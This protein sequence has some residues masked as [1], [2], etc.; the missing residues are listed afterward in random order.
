MTS[1]TPTGR[2][3]FV[4]S[5]VFFILVTAMLVVQ[6]FKPRARIA[7]SAEERLE[8]VGSLADLPEQSRRAYLPGDD[9]APLAKP[10]A[11]EW[12]A[13]FPEPGQTVDEYLRSGPNPF[14]PPRN[15]IYLLPL[16]TFP[17]GDSPSIELLREYTSL[18]F[19]AETMVLPAVDIKALGV[20]HRTNQHTKK[21]QYRTGDLLGVLKKQLPADAYCILG[22]TMADLYPD[23]AW[24][25]V[26]GEALL[27][28][29]AGV[30]SFARFDPAFFGEPRT[31][32][33]SSL[34]LRR[35]C[36]VLTHEAAHMF[37]MY[38][39][40]FYSCLVNG[41]NS[42][43]EADFRPMHECPV[44]LRKLQ[45]S[46]G[47]DP[48]ERYEKLAGFCEKV[49]FNDETGWLRSRLKTLRGR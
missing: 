23:D 24:N 16:G 29:R 2:L 26:F 12:L 22:I 47:F 33:A 7:I 32:D 14:A 45:R 8:A 3:W 44:C 18:Y 27:T 48:I 40:V 39:C 28:E 11:G 20:G 42:M 4:V 6:L 35:S 19:M 46:I 41:S 13:V 34:L 15:K 37:G 5:R 21:G 43:Q 30:F 31:A 1:L 38:H 36:K 17:E 9:F 49:G 10:K 25:F